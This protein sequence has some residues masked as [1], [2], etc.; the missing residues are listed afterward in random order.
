MYQEYNLESYKLY[1]IPTERFKRNTIRL[2]FR[3]QVKKEE[4]SGLLFTLG[5]LF[6]GSKKYPSGRELKIASDNLYA[7]GWSWGGSLSGNYL[8]CHIDFHFLDEKY[9]EE[10]MLDQTLQFFK[11]LLF[12]P[13]VENGGFDK[14]TVELVRLRMLEEIETEKE[15][16]GVYAVKKMKM[17]LSPDTPIS[18]SNIGYKQDYLELTAEDLY[19]YYQEC[20]KTCD[21]DVFVCGHVKD[22]NWKEKIRSFIPI[23]TIKKAKN[24]NPYIE[25]KSY[26]KKAQ[27]IIEQDENNQSK[28]VIGCK[29]DPLTSFER[30]Y[31][32]HVYSYILGGGADSYLFQ[33]VREK[34]SL[35]YS[36]SSGFQILNNIMTISAGIDGENLKKTVHLVK[37]QMKKMKKGE[38]TEEQIKNAM[39]VYVEAKHQLTDSVNGLISNVDNHI[40]YGYDLFERQMEEIE[41]VTKEDV[42]KLASKIHFDTIFLL[43]GVLK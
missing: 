1:V 11:E 9:T 35:C 32:T 14:E 17:Y 36:I 21:L 16:P 20:L 23:N 13:N 25:H 31:V 8:I 15:A 18:Y 39:T 41:K 7:A 26:R 38:F 40:H 28:L 34:N 33:N 19:E 5:V 2:V 27:T 3:R 10:G 30:Q 4:I 6:E 37:E 42:M 24:I 43:E 12:S 22:I 29:L